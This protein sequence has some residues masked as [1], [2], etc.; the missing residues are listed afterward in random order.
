MGGRCLTSPLSG[1]AVEAYAN[2][3]Q[4]VHLDSFETLTNCERMMFQLAA[5]G[6][7]GTEISEKIT[8]SAH[9]VETPRG[10]MMRKL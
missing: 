4:H 10:N 6:F 8:I 2:L 1:H 7:S 3:A 9:N 5:E